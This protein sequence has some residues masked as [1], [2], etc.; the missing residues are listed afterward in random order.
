[1]TQMGIFSFKPNY[2]FAKLRFKFFLLIIS[3]TVVIASPVCAKKHLV[4][5]VYDNVPL[6]YKDA[7]G[8][9]AGLS[10][11]V[12]EY[13][14]SEENWELEYLYGSWPECLR[15]LKDGETDLQILI[16]YTK[17]R[18]VVFDY[19]QESLFVV[20]GQVYTSPSV[21]ALNILDLKGKRIALYK[22]S[23]LSVAFKDL[24]EKFDIK[25]SLI[26]VEDYTAIVH[27]IRT[28]RAD[29]GVFNRTFAEQY[30]QKSDLHKTP[31]VFSPTPV[32]YA[33]PEGKHK[34]V[35]RAIDANLVRLKEDH[36]SIYYQSIE[37]SF[38]NLEGGTIPGWIKWALVGVS[39]LSVAI[40][41]VTIFL[42]RQVRIQTKELQSQN[43][44]LEQEVAERKVA[45]GELLKWGHI[46]KDA[47][48]GIAL[49]DANGKTYN[50][51]NPAY[52][53]M[54]GFSVEELTSKEISTMFVPAFREKLP[55]IIKKCH[56]LGH[57][58]FEG[59]HLRKDGT[60]FPVY[61]DVTTVRNEKGQVEYRVVN[62][63]DITD[64]IKA[65]KEKSKLESQLRQAHKME[66][67]G[68]LA[69]GIAH[70][71]NNIL[72]AILGYAE[73]VRDEVPEGSQVK[74][75][76]LEVLKAGKRAQD[77]VRHILAF[78]R[79]SEH[80]PVV[81]APHLI[82]EEA[83]TLL[84]ASIPTTI[85]ILQNIDSNCGSVL[86][87]PT[88]VHQVLMNLCTNAAQAMDN[89]GG[90]LEITLSCVELSEEVLQ[91]EPTLQFGQY[92]Q[93]TVGDSGPGI[94]SDLIDRIFDPY[95]TTKEI[96][97]GS[98]MGLAVVHGI[99]KSHNGMITVENRASGGTNFNVYFPRVE[100]TVLKEIEKVE[101]L[102]TGNERGLVVD[103]E[104]TVVEMTKRRLERLGYQ[105]TTETDS[106]RA[107]ELFR[108]APNSFD[109]IITDQTMPHMTGEQLAKAVLSI[110]PDIPIII[111]SGYNSQMGVEQTKVEGISA[112]IMKPIGKRK[113]AEIIRQV[114]GDKDKL[115]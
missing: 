109:F 100:K 63:I 27:E 76:I 88:Q 67:I 39:G 13:I 95:F 15:R 79:K 56:E 106:V 14:A 18:D 57:Y 115:E 26:E 3:I 83:I 71:F 1:M 89:E 40:G 11:E 8:R 78:S 68:T 31:I 73:M 60:S 47:Q 23:M 81:V 43:I 52:A 105:V 75:D 85:E 104:V 41:L 35:I 98:G 16:A 36:D 5:G 17:D 103:D 29:A 38:G 25:S 54:H 82:V 66:A 69:G 101:P 37:R 97:K 20:W 91:N 93:L 19:P 51:M 110:N 96:G 48:W 24:L 50:L 113:L 33:V 22:D 74:K 94:G 53:H 32:F 99:V 114:L 46:F 34:D 58:T 84:R 49:G 44:L 111:C 90:M 45:E 70:D 102:P 86:C 107:L 108:C 62:I 7:E 64:R 59:E 112:F 12:L 42:K 80:D 30:A 6:V 72:A 21:K 28:G 2:T 77:L 92:V 87:D 9:Y 10:V 55:G 61:H 4:V 65:E